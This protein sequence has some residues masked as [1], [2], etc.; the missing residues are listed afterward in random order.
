[1]AYHNIESDESLHTNAMMLI[2][3]ETNYIIQA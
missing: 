1:M 3:H 2:V